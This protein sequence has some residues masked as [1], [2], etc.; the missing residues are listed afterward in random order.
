M[1]WD[2]EVSVDEVRAAH[3][4]ASKVFSVY[5]GWPPPDAPNH[6]SQMVAAALGVI[7]SQ[8]VTWELSAHVVAAASRNNGGAHE[9]FAAWASV[10]YQTPHIEL[11]L[12][13]GEDVMNEPAAL[14]AAARVLTWSY[15]REVLD[16]VGYSIARFATSY[17][18][19]RERCRDHPSPAVCLLTCITQG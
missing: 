6:Q 13:E 8:S 5:N 11:P 18:V 12:L 14:G 1:P 7:A 10:D 4:N 2:R 16:D 15:N 19:C 9:Q 3:D 17:D